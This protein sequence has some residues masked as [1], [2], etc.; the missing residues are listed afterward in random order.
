MAEVFTPRKSP[1]D[2]FEYPRRRTRVSV[3]EKGCEKARGVAT[4]A[5]QA[6]S[7]YAWTGRWPGRVG[8]KQPVLRSF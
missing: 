3:Q 5:V 4:A 1:Q 7:I 8:T 2:H 6:G